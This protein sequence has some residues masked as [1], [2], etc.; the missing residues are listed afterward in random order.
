MFIITSLYE[1]N[2]CKSLMR[3][4]F[5][6]NHRNWEQVEN[7]TEK[8]FISEGNYFMKN[9][10]SSNWNFYKMKTALKRNQNFI[11]EAY[12][13][14][15]N[16]EDCYGHF[17]LVWGF[18]R[19]NEHLNRFTLSADGKRALVMH[20]EKDH[21]K[22]YHRFQNRQLSKINRKEPIRFS[23]IRMGDYFYFFINK[24]VAYT[25]HESMFADN[26][27][28]VGYYIEPGLEI[29]SNY[30]EVKKISAD[31]MDVTTGMQQLMN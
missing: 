26:G 17:G 21:R 7:E 30:I 4:E 18:D 12:L 8:A 28:Y 24:M 16:Y 20:F 14:L 5:K 6:N 3:E 1:V 15:E 11:L 22:I 13:Q 19:N 29:K 10:S 27:S 31:T 23:I 9:S 2:T 25:A